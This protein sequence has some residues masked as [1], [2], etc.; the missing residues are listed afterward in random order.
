MPVAAKKVVAVKKTTS[1]SKKSK[2]ASKKGDDDDEDD[3]GDDDDDEEDGKDEAM[4]KKD[5]L[6]LVKLSRMSQ[7]A[8]PTSFRQKMKMHSVSVSD[9]N[10][11]NLDWI[12]PTGADKNSVNIIQ[13]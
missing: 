5:G 9:N 2:S 10:K 7:Q 11:P 6:H 8:K 4:P 3:D 12:R 13:S 1:K